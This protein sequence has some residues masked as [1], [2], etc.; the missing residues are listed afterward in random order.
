MS[1]DMTRENS[2]RDADGKQRRSRAW[3]EA[4]ASFFNAFQRYSMQNFEKINEVAEGVKPDLR[5]R[6]RVPRYGATRLPSSKALWRDKAEN[7]FTTWVRRGAPLLASRATIRL[8]WRAEREINDNGRTPDTRI[9]GTGGQSVHA[10]SAYFTVFQ[11]ISTDFLFFCEEGTNAAFPIRWQSGTVSRCAHR[12]RSKQSRQRFS[13]N[14]GRDS[15]PEGHAGF[16]A[17]VF[18]VFDDGD[19]I[20]ED[21]FEA[22]GVMVRVFVGGV[23][24]NGGRIEY[25][26]VRP[27]AFAQLAAV[28][29][30]KRLG[31]EAGHFTDGILKA[32]DVKFTDVVCEDARVVTVAA[33]MG[34][35]F[36]EF[37]DAAI[38]GDHGVGELHEL[39]QI[40]FVHAVKN[41][42]SAVMGLDVQDHLDLVVKGVGAAFEFGGLGD[43]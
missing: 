39:L 36:A 37:A 32:E 13:G 22:G 8:R 11:F 6:R 29:E 16:G 24:L 25:D 26:D 33:R 17:G 19:A 23:F 1:Q 7:I 43:A 10:I 41:A 35:A 18:V 21:V 5:I 28:L 12:R 31:G 30:A 40:G 38:A 42:G 3:G 2:R 14:L 9:S 34:E 20:D 15:V 27:I 4:E